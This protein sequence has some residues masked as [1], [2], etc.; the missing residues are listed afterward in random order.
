MGCI[1]YDLCQI[2]YTLGWFLPVFISLFVVPVRPSNHY[3]RVW[4]LPSVGDTRYSHCFV[5]WCSPP[6]SHYLLEIRIDPTD[7]VV[8]YYA[9]CHI[10]F[11]KCITTKNMWVSNMSE[12]HT[13][14][15]VLLPT[16]FYLINRF[17]FY[18]FLT[19]AI[20]PVN[21]FELHICL[22]PTSCNMSV[23]LFD[24]Q[25]ISSSMVDFSDA[26]IRLHWYKTVHYTAAQNI[27]S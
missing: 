26:Y 18:K 2:N 5:I 14:L 8:T 4:A 19:S 11:A 25:P 27:K 15:L 16:I 9:Y 3:S 12:K 21:I 20:F 10:I 22:L 23:S 24:W 13:Y 7:N 6:P 17:N 1:H